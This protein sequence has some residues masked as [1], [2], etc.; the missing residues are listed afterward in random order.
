MFVSICYDPEMGATF[1]SSP[2]KQFRFPQR[3][4]ILSLYF[5]YSNDAYEFLLAEAF[6]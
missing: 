4:S 6:L 2:G 5:E 1:L 3:K